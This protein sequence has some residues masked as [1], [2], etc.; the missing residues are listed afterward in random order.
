MPD[1]ES[2]QSSE[3]RPYTGPMQS[4][5]AANWQNNELQPAFMREIA[6]V[7]LLSAE[8]ETALAKKM[9]DNQKLIRKKLEAYPDIILKRLQQIVNGAENEELDNELAEEDFVPQLSIQQIN[10]FLSWTEAHLANFKNW[11][12]VS[13]V[14]EIFKNEFFRRLENLSLRDQFYENCLNELLQKNKLLQKS[15]RF[16]SDSEVK[17]FQDA[18]FSLHSAKNSLVEANLRLVISIAKNYTGVLLPLA[19]LVQEGSIG[20]IRAVETFNYE[21]GHRLSTYST[22]LIRN[23]IGKALASKGRVIRMPAN[24]LQMLSKIKKCER[25]LLM[26]N[27]VVPAAQEIAEQLN[28]SAARVNA[29]KKMAQQPISLQSIAD[30]ERNWNELISDEKTLLPHEQIAVNSLHDVIKKALNVLDEKEQ[31]VIIRR[32]GLNNKKSETL[33]EIG[34]RLNLSGERIRQI[35]QTALKK[36]RDPQ[37]NKY[38]AGF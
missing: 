2:K 23:F 7:N 36:L 24:T 38:F 20:L 4:Y 30:G 10:L 28:I 19:D 33:D 32:F 9:R 12:E 1:N 17:L 29:L 8:E 31:E 26:K 18:I 27:G 15:E 35:E 16:L 6:K 21:L 34:N 22:Y 11:N 14:Q 25:E 5:F 37:I 3:A 13:P